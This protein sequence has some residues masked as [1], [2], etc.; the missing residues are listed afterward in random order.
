MGGG[1]LRN[2]GLSEEEKALWDKVAESVSPLLARRRRRKAAAPAPA[3]PLTEPVHDDAPVSAA[4]PTAHPPPPRHPAPEAPGKPKAKPSPT[5]LAPIDTRTRRK[6]V[7][8]TMAIEERLDLHG[9]TQHDAYRELRRFLAGAQARGT[10][11]V[12]VI[13]GKGRSSSGP[14]A[15][16]GEE[17]GILRRVVPQWLAMPDLRDVVIG[18]DEAHTA[19]GGA[20]A[21]YVRL[22]RPRHLT[23]EIDP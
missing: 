4:S 2:R 15:L 1:R 18:F 7:R 8:G 17:R 6:L 3:E 20:G 11:M 22:R 23:I 19:H 14:Y 5:P 10:R 13:T 9:M 12:I 16:G 21:L